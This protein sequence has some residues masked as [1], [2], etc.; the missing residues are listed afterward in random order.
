[1]DVTFTAGSR[2]FIGSATWDL[3]S[4]A[5]ADMLNGA[6][7]GDLYFPV[8]TVDDIPSGQLLGTYTV[9]VPEPGSLSLLGLCLGSGVLRR[10][11]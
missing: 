7:S 4:A 1:M 10:R 6:S 9:S 11:R 8:D 3:D 2:A 5:Y